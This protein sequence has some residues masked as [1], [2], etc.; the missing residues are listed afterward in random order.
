MIELK[1]S[2][3][4]L[5]M[6][7]A[8]EISAKALLKAKEFIVEGISTKEIDDE[9]R[10][11][12]LSKNAK[13]SFLGY[14]GFSGSACISINDEVI[15]GVP[16]KNKKLKNADIVSVDV[17]AYIDGYH[18]DN[19]FTFEV[20]E[21]S[22]SDKKLLTATQNSLYEAI[23]KCVPGN[24]VGDV[25]FAVQNYVENL[26]FSVVKEFVGHGI[27]RNLH[28]APEVPNYGEKG[29]G[30]RLVSGMT[31]AIEPM[32]NAG[33]EKVKILPDGW[34]VKTVDG[35]KSAHF[36]HTVLITNNEPIIL[37]KIR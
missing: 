26:G 35:K 12:I 24:R 21:V 31:I 27:G 5:K 23:K 9:I 20:G 16:N 6:Q 10:N 3:E 2:K 37:T 17:G 32:I 18:G 25:S 8:C 1:T 11:F 13:P 30:V 29:R 7:K 15:H 19:A 34:T 36:E 33:S 22:Q 28:E 4:I 14:G